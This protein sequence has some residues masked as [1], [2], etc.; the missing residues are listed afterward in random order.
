MRAVQINAHLPGTSA[1]CKFFIERNVWPWKLSSRSWSTHSQWCHSMTN[2]NLCKS[3][4]TYFCDSSNCL[5]DI[6]ISNFFTLKNFGQGHWVQH[7]Q[8]FQ[9]MTNMNLRKSYKW[10]FFAR[11]HRFWDI[12]ILWSWKKIGQCD[13]VQHSQSHHSMTSC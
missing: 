13:D 8:W 12:S 9:S 11:S 7:S 2:I 10:A 4:M 3:H 5:W 1:A 6:N